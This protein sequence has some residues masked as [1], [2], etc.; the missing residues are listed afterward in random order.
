M[1]TFEDY[2]PFVSLASTTRYP[3]QWKKE[4]NTVVWR[5]RQGLR[6]GILGRHYCPPP[7]PVSPSS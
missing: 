2:P 1:Y 3:V 6:I 7:K 4:S 5:T